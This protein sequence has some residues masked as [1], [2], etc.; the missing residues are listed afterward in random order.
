MNYVLV[1]RPEVRD[2]L[3]E[4]YNWYE[5]QQSGLGDDFLDCVDD[6]LN[7]IC[8]LPE[9]YAVVHRDVRRSLVRRFPYAVY[10]FFVSSRVIVIAIFHAQR[11]TQAWQSRT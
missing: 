6:K 9:A 7:Q 11:D 8:L 10:Y 4:A 1:F 2:E 3:D 5:S